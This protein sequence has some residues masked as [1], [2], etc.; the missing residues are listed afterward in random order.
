VGHIGQAPMHAH[1]ALELLGREQPEQLDEQ[2]TR[3]WERRSGNHARDHR[4]LPVA[5]N[6]YRVDELT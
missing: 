6:E 3:K 2:L 4:R 1:E 5:T